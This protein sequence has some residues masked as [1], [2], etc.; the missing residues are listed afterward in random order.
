[1]PMELS[2]KASLLRVRQAWNE[3]DGKI[4]QFAERL[5]ALEGGKPGAENVTVDRVLGGL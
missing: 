4:S 2:R 1:M 5:H 3:A